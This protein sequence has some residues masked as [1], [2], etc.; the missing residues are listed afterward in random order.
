MCWHLV[1]S[2]YPSF[3]PLH[4]VNL[5][6]HLFPHLCVSVHVCA[7]ASADRPGFLL[8]SAVNSQSAAF[9]ASGPVRQNFPKQ[10]MSNTA[11][12]CLHERHS[13][14]ICIFGKNT[15]THV[16]LTQTLTLS[17]SVFPVFA[18]Q[19]KMSMCVLGARSL[20]EN[21]HRGCEIKG[22]A[23]GEV[24]D[25]KVDDSPLVVRPLSCRGSLYALYAS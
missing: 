1:Q 18:K 14:L 2:L 17:K 15:K 21:S 22:R 20:K 13:L 23:N 4:S 16:Q 25:V 11:T 8:T 9:L 19:D 12:P 24:F 5:L 10:D 7:L 3:C 6:S